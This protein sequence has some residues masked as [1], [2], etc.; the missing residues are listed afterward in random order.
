MGLHI[1]VFRE[2]EVDTS[3]TVDLQLL[4][5]PVLPVALVVQETATPQA[6]G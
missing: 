4:I 5:Q 2:T 3:M 1:R 6:L